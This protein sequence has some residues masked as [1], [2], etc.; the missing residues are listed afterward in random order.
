MNNNMTRQQQIIQVRDVTKPIS[1]KDRLT[2]MRDI[3]EEALAEDFT[4]THIAGN[5]YGNHT[6]L[7]AHNGAHYVVQ[8]KRVSPQEQAISFHMPEGQQSRELIDAVEVVIRDVLG[9][10]NIGEH[11]DFMIE[12]G[13]LT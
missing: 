13:S 1:G 7:V 2:A 4:A 10:Y 11:K 6:Y 12:R 3:L 5:G 8:T 9:K